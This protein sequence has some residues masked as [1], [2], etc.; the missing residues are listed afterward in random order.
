MLRLIAVG[1]ITVPTAGGTWGV[2]IPGKLAGVLAGT[3]EVR[4]AGVLAAKLVGVR[5]LATAEGC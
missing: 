2:A 5:A 3:V 1:A 4:S